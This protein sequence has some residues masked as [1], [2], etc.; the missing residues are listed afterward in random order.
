MESRLL[1]TTTA[2]RLESVRLTRQLISPLEPPRAVTP[3]AI[4]HVD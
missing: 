3:G 1:D 4:H 2:G